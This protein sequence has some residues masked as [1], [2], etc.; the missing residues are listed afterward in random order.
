MNAQSLITALEQQRNQAL[1]QNAT[2]MAENLELKAK[3]S[4]LEKLLPTEA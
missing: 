2:L 4:E 1:N 3:I